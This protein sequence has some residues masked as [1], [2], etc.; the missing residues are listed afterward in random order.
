[1]KNMKRSNLTYEME[2][3]EEVE[4]SLSFG[5]LMWLNS[6][7]KELYHKV[8]KVLARGMDDVLETATVLYAAY[9]CANADGDKLMTYKSFLEGMNQSIDYN[10]SA[11]KELV[12]PPKK[13]D[14]ETYF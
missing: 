7:N 11:V 4:M 2:N 9:Y 12:D 13:P 10:T 8:N 1:M 6:E 14:S 5:K 3:G